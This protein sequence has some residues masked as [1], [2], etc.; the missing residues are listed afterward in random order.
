[1]LSRVADSIYW[2]SRYIER[3]EN[4]AR[5]IDVNMHL[6]LDLP[7]GFDDQWHPLVS[8]TGDQAIFAERYGPPTRKNVI[9][10]PAQ[11]DQRGQRF[12]SGSQGYLERGQRLATRASGPARGT[13]RE[14]ETEAAQTPQPGQSAPWLIRTA[15]CVEPRS[16]RLHVFMPPVRALEDYIDLV[17]AIEDTATELTTQSVV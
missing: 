5:F 9:E 17:A 13:T 16:G 1:M 6:M 4:V 8:T 2:M 3:A 12:V 7:A 15:L 11:P 14:F 10:F